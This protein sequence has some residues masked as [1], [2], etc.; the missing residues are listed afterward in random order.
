M[1]NYRRRRGKKRKM[2]KNGKVII[3]VLF[4]TFLL[5]T[6]FIAGGTFFRRSTSKVKAVSAAQDN[7]EKTVVDTATT[8]PDRAAV[9]EK[10]EMNIPETPKVEKELNNSAKPDGS[11]VA[12]LTFDD[13]PS[14]EV[15]PKVLDILDKYNIKATFFVT[16]YM[17]ERNKDILMREWKDGQAIGNHS[18]SH[19]YKYLYANVSNFISDINKCNQVI[20]SILGNDYKNKIIRF[21]GG[22]FGKK[23]EPYRNE[24]Q[25]AGYHYVD[26][27]ALSGDA[28][29]N[30][31]SVD[32]LIKR[33]EETT[34]GKSHVIIL[35]HDAPQKGTTAEALPGIIEYLSKQGYVFKTLN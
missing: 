31:N 8:T 9:P 16:G 25:K 12:Y 3:G 2:G 10:R 14:K 17:S 20:V 4:F 13:G 30:V 21:P 7:V 18:Y 5:T 1:Y 34:K 22:S 35:M 11:K 28:E 6:G 23:L 26:W 24:I 19:D 27:N 32:K 29:S 33:V 15:T